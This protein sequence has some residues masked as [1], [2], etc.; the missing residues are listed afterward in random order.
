MTEFAMLYLENTCGIKI[1]NIINLLKK[2]N[3][4]NFVTKRFRSC[5]V[6]FRGSIVRF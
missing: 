4:L 6:T 5:T 3:K 2:K 1:Y